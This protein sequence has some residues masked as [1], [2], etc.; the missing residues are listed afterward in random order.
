MKTQTNNKLV[1]AKNQVIAMVILSAL[2]L[3]LV[4]LDVCME[5]YLFS[6][7]KSAKEFPAA[8]NYLH[9]GY[10]TV[11]LISIIVVLVL[12]STTY[13]IYKKNKKINKWKNGMF[14]TNWFFTCLYLVLSVV[15]IILLRI[16]TP[17]LIQ[18]FLA[19]FSVLPFVVITTISSIILTYI[20][21]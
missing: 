11:E 3:L 4:M 7:G 9:I 1:S 2:S 15:A 18:A 14:I 17:P 19:G 8:F 21:E 16:D 13:S 20:K 12:T 5:L 6:T 10:A